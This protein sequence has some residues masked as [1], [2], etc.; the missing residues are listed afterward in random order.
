MAITNKK[1]KKPSRNISNGK[2]KRNGKGN[3]NTKVSNRKVSNTKGKRRRTKSKSKGVAGKK[4]TWKVGDCVKPKGMPGHYKILKSLNDNEW[5]MKGA[6]RYD[7]A[8]PKLVEFRG[9]VKVKC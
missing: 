6:N 7:E 8:I 9:W 4:F 1:V 5:W 3:R 2:G